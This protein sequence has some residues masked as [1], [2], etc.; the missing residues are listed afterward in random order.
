MEQRQ[1]TWRY[2]S[3]K[4]ICHELGW[5]NGRQYPWILPRNQWEQNLWPAIRSGK[6]NSL[7]QYIAKTGI[8]PH[9]GKHNLKSS[10]VLCANLYFPFRATAEG[11]AL[12]AGFLREHVSP[13]IEAVDELHLEFA[14][15]G[16]LHPANLLGEPGGQRGSGQTSPDLA[17]HVNGRRGLILIENKL[18][19]H[20]FYPCSARRRTGSDERPGNP[21]PKRCEDIESILANHQAQCHQCHPK[22]HRKYWDI[23]RPV[24]NEQAMGALNCC[25]AAYAGY[26]LF[27]QQALAEGIAQ[28]GKYDFVWSCVALD[29]RNEALLTCLAKTGIA[30]LESGWAALFRGKARFK[31]FTHQQWVSWVKA[32][33]D[34]AAWGP[35]LDYVSERYGLLESI[36]AT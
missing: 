8:Q 24:V 13:E 30:D 1:I 14:E 5:Q 4:G 3:K 23:L 32:H 12:L 29:A 36:S 21:F 7:P 28:S 10:W 20:S 34:P 26:Q 25:P 19:E 2:K 18:T 22:W 17:F 16:E 27:R 31:V 35:W 11:M 6:S 15:E 9:P 33:G